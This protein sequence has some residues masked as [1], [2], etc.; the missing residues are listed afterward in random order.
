MKIR[1]LLFVLLV[2][3]PVF[4]QEPAKSQTQCHHIISGAQLAADELVIG[5]K[6]CRKIQP[7]PT[8]ETPTISMSVQAAVV[9]PEPI[10]TAAVTPFQPNSPA[11]VPAQPAAPAPVPLSPPEGKLRVYVTDRPQTTEIMKT[12]NQ[13]CP[14]VAITN[15]IAKAD[16]DV[17]LD[18]EGGKGY[19][20]RRNKIAVFNRGGDDIFTDSTRE[21]GNAVKDACRAMLFS[22]SRR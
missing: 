7:A 13:R 21:L 6:V 4:A 9:T 8:G 12:F 10:H 22:V 19:L 18:H 14:E 20:H 17:T 16:F 2:V 3:T 5:D 1:A 11:S 15:N